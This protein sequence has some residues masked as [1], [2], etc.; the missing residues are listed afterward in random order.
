MTVPTVLNFP[1]PLYCTSCIL[2]LFSSLCTLHSPLVSPHVSRKWSPKQIPFLLLLP[3]IINSDQPSRSTSWTA[4]SPKNKPRQHDFYVWQNIGPGQTGIR[5]RQDAG[6]VHKEATGLETEGGGDI[7]FAWSLRQA[8][9]T[10]YSLQ[11]HREL[12]SIIGREKFC[13]CKVGEL[14][15]SSEASVSQNNV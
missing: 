8:T 12:W 14:T 13:A 6:R 5:G 1:L 15:S 9:L 3:G 4:H 10:S 2:P 7:K 11:L